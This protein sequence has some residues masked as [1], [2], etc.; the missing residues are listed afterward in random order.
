MAYDALWEV[1]NNM[2]GCHIVH[3]ANAPRGWEYEDYIKHSLEMLRHCDAIYLMP[4][5]ET[6]EGVKRELAE[7]ALLGRP[8]F[9]CIEDL[10]AWIGGRD[11]GDG[12]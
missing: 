1:A 3:T 7:A 9:E 5:W 11:D 8:V 4:G 6:S 2:T 10:Q 12:R